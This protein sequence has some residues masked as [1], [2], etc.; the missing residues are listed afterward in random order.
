[1]SDKREVLYHLIDL[2]L[3]YIY[4]CVGI[5]VYGGVYVCVY[6][7]VYARVYVCMYVCIY[8]YIYIYICMSIYFLLL[9]Y[10]RYNCMRTIHMYVYN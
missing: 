9:K 8:I 10:P 2:Y 6:V 4:V 7:Y 1:M 5:C 3:W